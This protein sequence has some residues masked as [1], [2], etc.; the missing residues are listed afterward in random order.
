[1]FAKSISS[2]ADTNAPGTG[3]ANFAASDAAGRAIVNAADTSC[4]VL[5]AVEAAPLAWATLSTLSTVAFKLLTILLKVDN[6]S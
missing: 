3:T 4:I 1:M 6:A 5:S 2:I